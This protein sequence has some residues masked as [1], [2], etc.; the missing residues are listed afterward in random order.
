MRTAV[1]G[2]V[3]VAFAGA[4]FAQP[5]G[6]TSS[7]GMFTVKFPGAPKVNT[8]S[9]KTAVGD[10]K[11]TVATYANA[12]GSVFMVSYTDFPETVTKPENHATLLDGIRDGVKGSNGKLVGDEKNVKFGPDKLTGR[13]FT[14]DKDKAKQRIK[15]LVVIRDGRV[16]QVAAIGTPE[17]ANGKDAT[18]FL[19]SFELTK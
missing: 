19:E 5:D 11:V 18:A 3:L 16:Y 14:V 8:Q 12:D 15:F 10:L 7:A 17:F 6:Y 1:I 4:A 13:E 2:F 9:T